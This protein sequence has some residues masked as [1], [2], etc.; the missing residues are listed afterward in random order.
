MNKKTR[1]KNFNI[2]LKPLCVVLSIVMLLSS[3]I[4]FDFPEL[5]ATAAGYNGPISYP[6]RTTFLYSQDGGTTWKNLGNSYIATENENTLIKIKFDV[7]KVTEDFKYYYSSPPG[8]LQWGGL[9]YWVKQDGD[10]N[11]GLAAAPK[12][13]Q[14]AIKD[15]DSNGTK[16]INSFRVDAWAAK[17][18]LEM[19]QSSLFKFDRTFT[20]YY[21]NK[22]PF[23]AKLN[24]TK[25]TNSDIPGEQERVETIPTNMQHVLYE[26]A[27]CLSENTNAAY[28]GCL[29]IDRDSYAN[30]FWPHIPHSY[31]ALQEHSHS[32]D[33][34]DAINKAMDGNQMM[35]LN[36]IDSWKRADEVAADALSF[37]KFLEKN[38][39]T[40]DTMTFANTYE[41]VID[42]RYNRAGGLTPDQLTGSYQIEVENGAAKSEP[43][44]LSF[45][46]LTV[47]YEELNI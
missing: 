20:S 9:G 33:I 34:K 35:T 36:P 3:F 5:K 41:Y 15:V 37:N 30:G 26:S 4:F 7:A 14:D 24:G 39:L 19:K 28:N 25:I 2:M 6:S 46:E 40:W 1:D 23:Y 42:L 8:C 31:K 32:D 44:N 13:T 29:I 22:L 16:W 10:Y 27:S 18:S 38:G 11:V 43:F 45:S 21:G 47:K 12:K 17:R